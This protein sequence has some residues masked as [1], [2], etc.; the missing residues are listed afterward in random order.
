[1][2]AGGVSL[3]LVAVSGGIAWFANILFQTLFL[4]TT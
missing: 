2:Q 1:M 4:Y 3:I